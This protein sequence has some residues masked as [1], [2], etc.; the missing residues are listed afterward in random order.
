M[1]FFKFDDAGACF[2][3][4]PSLEYPFLHCLIDAFRFLGFLLWFVL[5]PEGLRG[6][7]LGPPDPSG[8]GSKNIKP[9][10]SAGPY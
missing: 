8:P 4:H 10:V 3:E 6:A 1:P 5:G 2:P 7:S 9:I